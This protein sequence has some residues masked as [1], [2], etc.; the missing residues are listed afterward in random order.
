MLVRYGRCL[1]EEYIRGLELTVGILGSESLPPIQIRTR[2]SFYNYEAKYVDNETEYLFDIDLPEPI[3]QQIRSLSLKAH[4][5][6]GCRDFSRVDWMVDAATHQ[7]YVLE[8]NTIPGFTDHSLLPKAAREA[9][10]SFPDL[11][12]RIVQLAYERE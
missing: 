2:R 10:F 5:A 12:Q 1:I 8:V 11:C 4:Q 9:G 7:A 3:L 6:L